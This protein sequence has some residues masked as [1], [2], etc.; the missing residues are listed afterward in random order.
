MSDNG[1]LRGEVTIL[2]NWVQTIA[3]RLDQFIARDAEGRKSSRRYT[4]STVIA[5]AS[6]VFLALGLIGGLIAAA[7]L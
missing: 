5:A 2:H 7:T 1:E 4:L 6:V 3:N